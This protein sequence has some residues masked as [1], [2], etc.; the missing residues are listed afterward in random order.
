MQYNG[1]QSSE[2][3][4]KLILFKN[5]NIVKF[6]INSSIVNFDVDGHT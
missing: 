1:W 4:V 2:Q 5:I 3:G 6:Q